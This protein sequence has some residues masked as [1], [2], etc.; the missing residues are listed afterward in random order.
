[1]TIGA[2]ARARRLRERQRGNADQTYRRLQRRDDMPA[3]RRSGGGGRAVD[4][5][6][7][8]GSLRSRRHLVGAN[9]DQPQRPQDRV[10]CADR[11]PRNPAPPRTRRP[12]RAA[13][14]PRSWGSAP[15]GS[16]SCPG[17]P[18]FG[19]AAVGRVVSRRTHRRG[20]RASGLTRTR[21]GHQPGTL[22]VP[23]ALSPRR[24]TEIPQ[25]FIE[26]TQLALC[27]ALTSLRAATIS[28]YWR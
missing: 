19:R 20:S 2:G 18:A 3:R 10:Q 13:R 9:P 16:A 8:P 11:Q 21:P 26:P 17:H 12:A 28:P 7:D 22:R 27:R 1:M 5:R 24:T 25:G 15:S 23:V 14:A 6:A 4:A